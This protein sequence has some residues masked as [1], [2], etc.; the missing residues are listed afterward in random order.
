M[1]KEFERFSDT[2]DQAQ[3]IN[4]KHME[5]SIEAAR[6]LN[7]PEQVQ[8]PD[9]TWPEPDCIDCGEEIPEPRLKLG[10]VRCVECQEVLERKRKL[11]I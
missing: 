11:G 9:G 10:R 8:N 2:L 7:K 4:E 5:A 1:T 3:Q 6:S